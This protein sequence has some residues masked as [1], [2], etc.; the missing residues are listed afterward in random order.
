MTFSPREWMMVVA[1]AAAVGAAGLARAD[2]VFSDG[3]S[4][5]SGGR[6]GV[7]IA[8]SDNGALILDN[9]AGLVNIPEA[10]YA[11]LDFAMVFGDLEYSDPQN[12]GV[13][14]GFSFPENASPLAGISYVQKTADESLAYGIGIFTPAGFGTLFD[15][16]TT[17]AGQQ[18]YRSLDVLTRVLPTA[19]VRLTDR[20]SVGAAFGV[21][22]N[23]AELEG[24]LFIQTGPLAGAPMIADLQAT[25]AEPTW[26]V[27]LQYAV[28]DSTTIGLS[29]I[30]EIRFRNQEGEATLDVFGLAPVPLRSQFVFDM[31]LA[32]PRILGGG[33]KHDLTSQLSV[34]ADVVWFDWSHAFDQID[35]EFSNPTNPAF[36]A[37]FTDV[38]PLNWKDTVSV[39][40]G[41]EYGFCNCQTVRAGYVHRPSPIP[42]STFVTYIPPVF[43]H[44]LTIGY[45]RSF[46]SWTVD[47]SYIY[48]FGPDMQVGTSSLLG[49][50]FSNSVLK[51]QYHTV[52]LGVS[53]KL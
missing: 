22:I 27:G 48:L 46:G 39:R 8:H 41:V 11:G 36:P 16:Q 32:Y 7:N 37:R 4:A 9:P 40:V 31:D 1:A 21:A 2:G 24:P 33:V 29:Y 42:S 19:A 18:R 26:N 34:S 47:L 10:G 49:G 28:S 43:E 13:S 51:E 30:D 20:L 50:D 6:G 23:H 5:R 14:M 12:D 35:V 3:F 15:L 44:D 52:F 17:F 53:K 25:G 38:L 45:S